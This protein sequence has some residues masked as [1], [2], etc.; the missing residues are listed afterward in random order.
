MTL[1]RALASVLRVAALLLLTGPAFGQDASANFPTKPVKLIVPY[2]PG[3]LP[4]TMARIVAQRLSESLGQ[5]FVVDNRPSAG[6][7]IACEM[8]ASAVADGYT[9]LV[10]DVGQTAINPALYRKLS[11]NPVSDF[12]PVSL[13]GT[14]P[15]F[16][17]A[18][19]SVPASN[20]SE[21]MVLLKSKP[22]QINYGSAGIGSVHHLTMEMLKAQAR[23]NVIHVPY[24]GSGQSVP[25][26]VGGQVSLLFTALPAMA[27]HIKAG[28]VKVFAVNT[29]ERSAQ[30][31]NVPTFTE[32]G[33][34]DM[35]LIPEIGI[36]APAATPG[37]VVNKLSAE[38]AKAVRNPDTVQRFKTLG[39]DPVGNSPEAYA[40][41]IRA[42]IGKYARAVKL[43]GAT[44][45]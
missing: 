20:F 41:L 42:D 28:S 32:L 15:L 33:I 23:V 26:L 7:L 45:D 29:L 27:A 38:I 24:K 40:A 44:A 35:D 5:Q 2:A 6:G 17:V 36:L 21:L 37:P 8:V 1:I 30:E 19:A 3:G 25:A 16:L 31:P 34:P 18:H 4:D 13:M 39:I 12:A 22:G 14:S 9:L 10:A 11:Y 43:S